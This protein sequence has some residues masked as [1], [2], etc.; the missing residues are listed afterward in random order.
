MAQNGIEINTSSNMNTYKIGKTNYILLNLH[1]F[2]FKEDCG[3]YKV[4]NKNRG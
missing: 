3:I 2:V 1:K 4:N